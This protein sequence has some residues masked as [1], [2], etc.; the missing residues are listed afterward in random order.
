M[1]T[2]SRQVASGILIRVKRELTADFRIIKMM[3][4]D[5]DKSEVVH[6]D[7]WKCGVHFKI[8]S[9]CIPHCNHPDFSY[10]NHVKHSIFIR[11][12]N[13]PSS[14]WGY[15]DTNEFDRRI[16][17]FLNST[18]FE[19]LYKKKDPL[20][21]LPYNA[22]SKVYDGIG[23]LKRADNPSK[24]TYFTERGMMS[25][26]VRKDRRQTPAYIAEDTYFSK[27]SFEGIHSFWKADAESDVY[28]NCSNLSKRPLIRVIEYLLYCLKKYIIKNASFTI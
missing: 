8:L 5:S 3:E 16:Q 12:F 10:V 7:V 23:I 1:L 15:S 24:T 18:T 21:Y 26:C 22:R 27:T 17:D 6:L 19:L 2:K 11:D 4:V 14:V 25:E 20:T 13:A 28:D 9:I